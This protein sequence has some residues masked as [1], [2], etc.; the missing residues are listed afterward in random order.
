MRIAVNTRLLLKDKLEGMGWFTHEILRKMVAQHPEDE[1]FFF[2]D[3]P[4][5]A[6]FVFAPHVTPVVLFPPA[7]HPILFYGW[8][9]WA[10]PRAL[11]KYQI[12]VFLSPDNFCS[13]RTKVPTVLVVHDLAYLHF[14][15]HTRRRD[16]W[17]YRYF[18]PRYV[19]RANRII[20]VSEFTKQDIIKQF[21]ITGERIAVA[22]NGV[23][24]VFQPISDTEKEHIKTEYT[25]GSDYFFYVGAVHPRKNVPRLIQAFDQFKTSASSSVK[26][27]LAG[28]FGW[29]T[30]EVKTAY[31]QAKHQKDILFLGYTEENLLPKLMAASTALIYISHFEGF[32]VPLLEAMH[33]EVPIIAADCAALP[34]VSGKAA[35]LVNPNIISEIVVAMANIV[36]NET[37]RVNLILEGKRQREKFSWTNSAAIV[38]QQ[39]LE[40]TGE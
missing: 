13:I 36:D 14:P 39:L 32:G 26:L 30:G 12:D 15:I 1:F 40:A 19:E 22:Y 3:R 8:Y 7:R 37:V 21:G 4:F 38:Y 17:Y 29:Q 18:T 33:C 6:C 9:E 28:R 24:T 25:E 16:L 11:K 20:T 10:V 5:D 31:E 34:E 2:F 35:L 23:R 27:V